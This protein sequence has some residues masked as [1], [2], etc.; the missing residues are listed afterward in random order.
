ML[1]TDATRQRTEAAAHFP[2]QLVAA[3]ERQKARALLLRAPSAGRPLWGEQYHSPS[4]HRP[5]IADLSNG[6]RRP[7]L[8]TAA[9]AATAAS[10]WSA[11]AARRKSAGL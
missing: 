5:D 7:S 6:V 9:T 3:A 4:A 8:S 11:T 1:S 10:R 2:S